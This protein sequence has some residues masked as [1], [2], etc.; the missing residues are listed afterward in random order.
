MDNGSGLPVE[1]S[2]YTL[3]KPYAILNAVDWAWILRSIHLQ[4][5]LKTYMDFI[6][7]NFRIL[8]HQLEELFEFS[9]I[10]EYSLLF[11]DQ[12]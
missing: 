7:C 1:T 12:A 9:S 3:N 6:S 4:K 8:L 2:E 11:H 5:R 10:L